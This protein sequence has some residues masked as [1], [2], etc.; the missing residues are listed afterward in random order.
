MDGILAFP[1]RCNEQ[2]QLIRLRDQSVCAH[3]SDEQDVAVYVVQD[4]QFIYTV[5]YHDGVLIRY[6]KAHLRVDKNVFI[7][8][9]AGCHQVVLTKRCV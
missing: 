2:A 6:E 8:K 3:E 9:E 5:N 4:E 1:C 7:Q